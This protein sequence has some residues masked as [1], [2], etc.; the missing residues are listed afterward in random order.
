[1]PKDN[2]Y[3]QWRDELGVMFQDEDF[4]HLYPAEG[5][6]AFCPWRLAL[7]TVMQFVENLSDRQ[8]AEAVRARIDWKYVLGLELTHTGFNYSVLCEFRERLVKGDAASLLLNRMLE[9]MGHKKLLKARGRQRTDST[10]VL[11]SIRVMNRLELITETLRA[12]LN[13][14]A[15][16]VPEWLQSVVPDFWYERYCLRA[17]QSRL[18]RGEQVRQH[19]AQT[20]GQDGFLL[21]SLVEQQKPELITLEKLVTLRQVWERHF[22]RDKDSSSNEDGPH[23]DR[24]VVIFRASAELSRAA[25]AI[26]SP[27]DTQARHST[28][29]DLTWTGYKVHISETCDPALPRLITHVHTTPA[30]TQDVSCT[31]DIHLALASKELLPNL[32]LVDAGYTDAQL[33]VHSQEQH[34][35][36]L[37]G[38]TRLNPSWQAREGGFDTTLFVID[39]DKQQARC[40]QGKTSVSWLPRVTQPYHRELVKI[41]FS[42][43]DCSPCS[44]RTRCVRSPTGQSR[45][46]NVPNQAEFEAL[47]RARER[48][49][50][51]QGQKEY[52]LRAGVEGTLSQAVRR[53]GLRQ[54]RY[55]GLAKTHLQHVATAVA[56]N[57]LRSVEH[58]CHKRRAQTRTSRFARL[59]F[60]A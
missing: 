34:R 5:Q 43:R 46:L 12:A 45:S 8:A 37:L 14:L 49:T 58:L 1:L 28:K 15:S 31:S 38:P 23:E 55:R 10:H 47:V 50:T 57:T 26:E 30:T 24:P 19:Y 2:L 29:R 18:P 41:R 42:T 53:S 20:V 35:V 4:A 60:A 9:H 3:L 39:W 13:E 7:V 48:L 51:P 36:D 27:Y 16:V 44:Q 22:D 52:Q 11:A 59:A 6:P 32:H 21:L 40:P 56:L 17:E 33:L 25:Q 54:A